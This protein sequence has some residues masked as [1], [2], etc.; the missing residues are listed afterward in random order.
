[1]EITEQTLTLQ[2]ADGHTFAGFRASP[3]AD[4]KGGLVILQEIFGLTDQLRSV[5]RSFAAE[6]FDA[7]VPALFDRTAPDTVIPFETPPKGL[8]LAMG[9]DPEKVT[10]DVAAAMAAVDSGK[11]VSLMGYCWGGG[12]ALR[13]ACQLPCTSAVAYYGTSLDKHLAGCPEGPK[14]PMLFHFGDSDNYTPPPLIDAVRAA[15]PRAEIHL[16]AAGHAFTNAARPVYVKEAAVVA[17]RRTVEFLTRHHG[18]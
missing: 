16:Y 18:A 12:Q 10:A 14:C 6:G 11:G 7:I 17:N 9:L 3:A 8:E 4:P 2:A 1:M 5:A 13:L 15:I